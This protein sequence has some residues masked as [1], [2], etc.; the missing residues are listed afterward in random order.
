MDPGNGKKPSVFCRLA[1][2]ILDQLRVSAGLCGLKEW[3]AD[4][5]ALMG[6]HLSLL[7]SY[8]LAIEDFKEALA[9]LRGNQL[10]DYKILG[11]QFR[12]FACEVRPVQGL[13][14]FETNEGSREAWE[15]KE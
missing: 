4:R 15:V 7:Y 5:L 10:I 3:Q 13:A 9:Q 2:V 12:L 6:Y 11:L 14:L 1:E 8:E